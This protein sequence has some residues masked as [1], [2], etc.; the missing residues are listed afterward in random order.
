MGCLLHKKSSVFQ[1]LIIILLPF[2]IGCGPTPTKDNIKTL[3]VRDF[4][5]RHYRVTDLQIS[6][7]KP[8]AG[9][10][11][12]MGSKSYIVHIP[13]ITFEATQDIGSPVF[14][15][16]GQKFSFK[17]A[18]VKIKEDLYKKGKWTIKDIKGIPVP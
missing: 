4:E 13:L 16:K 1:V 14:Y 11:I 9:E 18:S 12:Y 10:E 2:L 15:I 7:I 6:D 17:N 5:A 8:S 3:I